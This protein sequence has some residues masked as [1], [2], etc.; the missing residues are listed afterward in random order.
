[1]QRREFSIMAD[2]ND[3]YNTVTSLRLYNLH[4]PHQFERNKTQP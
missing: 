1:M 4:F 3:K 2:L